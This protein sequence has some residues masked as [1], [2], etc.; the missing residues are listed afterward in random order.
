MSSPEELIL[1]TALEGGYPIYV[2][3]ERELSLKRRPPKVASTFFVVSVEETVEEL[4]HPL[5]ERLRAAIREVTKKEE[6]VKRFRIVYEAYRGDR[7]E[8]V[9]TASAYVIKVVTA[10]TPYSGVKGEAE[11]KRAF[12]IAYDWLKRITARVPEARSYGGVEKEVHLK[13][14][15]VKVFFKLPV[16]TLDFNN[17]FN[18]LVLGL[19]PSP[20][21]PAP[22]EEVAPPAPPALELVVP[23]VEI[24]DV[25]PPVEGPA[26]APPAEERPRGQVQLLEGELAREAS[27][28][29]KE[30]LREQ[31][32]AVVNVVAFDLPSEYRGTSS[33]W[34]EDEEGRYVERRRFNRKAEEVAR[35]RTLRRKFY[36]LLNAYAFRT[37]LG[38]VVAGAVPEGLRSAASDIARAAGG[39]VHWLEVPLPAAWLRLQAEAAEKRL[40]ATLEEVARRLGE[41]AVNTAVRRRLE[42]RRSEVEATLRRLRSFLSSLPG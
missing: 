8:L 29:L 30:L 10:D 37:P 41:E 12:A 13:R 24:T 15:Y 21:A 17:L 38:W 32:Y 36:N 14:T 33:E 9:G 19:P 4:S 28:A 3:E 11:V 20:A 39:E 23:E 1:A 27:E 35:I 40:A 25:V 22:A 34:E 5:L 42:R 16:S 18:T 7:E 2:T 26:P 31:G 6:K